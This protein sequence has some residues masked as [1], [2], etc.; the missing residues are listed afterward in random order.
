MLCLPLTLSAQ[1]IDHGT[2]MRTDDNLTIGSSSNSY[3]F[4][5]K[6]NDPGWQARF[7]NKEG[8]GADIYIAHENGHGMIIRGYTTDGKYTL[9][10]KNLNDDTNVFYNNGKVGLGLQ[11]NV[12]IG[13]TAPS[14]KLHVE[15]EAFINGNLYLT[16]PSANN[17]NGG[18][19]ILASGVDAG[20]THSIGIKNYWT[21]F[22]SHA[23]EGWKFITSTAAN[24]DVVKMII[25]GGS[26]KVSIGNVATTSNNYKLFVEKGIL[27]EKVKVAVKSTGDWSDYVFEENYELMSIDELEEYTTKNKHL[28]NVPSAE[29]VVESGLDVATMD[30]KLL[31]KI[32]EAH[33][34]IIELHKE[35]EQLK[36]SNDKK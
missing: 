5:V 19:L 13:T 21:E 27:T 28:P 1:L 36:R 9:K 23:N 16:S 22:R 14:K 31:E 3:A 15:G 24:A 34:Y 33:L 6:K 8:A 12:G 18:K 30:A 7:S 10:L 35:I 25:E 29:E 4:Y 2:Y 20:S 17:G 11:G 32:E 26:G